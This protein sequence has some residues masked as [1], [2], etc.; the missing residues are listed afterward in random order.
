MPPKKKEQDDVVPWANSDAKKQLYNDIVD[1]LVTAD[2][3]PATVR[4]MHPDLYKPYEKNFGTNYRSLQKSI[5]KHQARADED[6]A[7]LA[8][9]LELHPTPTH[10][11]RGY[12]RWKHSKY[13]KMLKQDIKDG[14]HKTMYPRELHKERAEYEEFPLEVFRMHIHQETR[15]QKNRSY[16]MARKNNKES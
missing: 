7:A 12:P 5:A 9:D 4:A 6:A 15:S 1:R 8:H 11:P 16:W 13:E 14:L 2:M 3:M 10:G